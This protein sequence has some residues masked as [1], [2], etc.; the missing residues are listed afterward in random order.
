[1]G[2]IYQFGRRSNVR[3]KI[4]EIYD[5]KKVR[6]FLS[7]SHFTRSILKSPINITYLFPP[8]NFSERGFRYLSLN[9]VCCLHGC[10]YMHPTTIFSEFCWII[11]KQLTPA[12]ISHKLLSLVSGYSRLLFWYTVY[13][14]TL[15]ILADSVGIYSML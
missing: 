10:L 15:A 8:I 6:T 9:Y 14:V 12:T 1:M 7:E 2:T 3:D 11:S 5:V 4:R 13:T